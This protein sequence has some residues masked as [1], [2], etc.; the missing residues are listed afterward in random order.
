VT[1]SPESILRSNERGAAERVSLL[2]A[3]LGRRI[4]AW[5]H[6]YPSQIGQLA[7]QGNHFAAWQEPDLLQLRLALRLGRC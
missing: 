2:G 5:V 1:V 7:G 3:S 4:S 6:R